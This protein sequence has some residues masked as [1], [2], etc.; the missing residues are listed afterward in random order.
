MNIHA[1][2]VWVQQASPCMQLANDITFNMDNFVVGPKLR[3]GRNGDPMLVYVW[4]VEIH[5]YIYKYIYIWFLRLSTADIPID[6][7]TCPMRIFL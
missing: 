4:C 3:P 5:V 6:M 2:K 1:H 7:G